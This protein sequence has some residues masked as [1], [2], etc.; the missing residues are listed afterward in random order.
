MAGR[1]A[2]HLFI[3]SSLFSLAGAVQLRYDFS[4][5]L[6]YSALTVAFLIPLAFLYFVKSRDVYATGKFHFVLIT[7]AWGVI[8]YFLAAQI[9]PA[10]I[11]AGWATRL[12]V[13]RFAGPI[14]EELLKSLILIYLVQRADY[15]YVVDGAIY[16][17]GAGIGFAIIENTEYIFGNPEIA[18]IVALAR[19]FSTNLVH[20]AGSGLIGVALSTNRVERGA[21]GMFLVL[22]GYLFSMAF[23]MGFNTMVNSGTILI[24]AVIF[25]MTEGGLII[26]AI[27]RGLHVQKGWMAEK[28]GDLNRVTKNEVQ[29]LNKMEQLDELLKPLALQFGD[30]KAAQVK[31]MLSKQAEMGIKTKLLESTF[32]ESKKQEMNG[33]IGSLRAE[34]E[35]LRGEIGFYC[36]LFVRQV[37]LSQDMN[38]WGA[39]NARIAESSTGQKGGGLWDRVSSRVDAS[40]SQEDEPL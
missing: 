6:I 5:F 1:N 11:D 36:M 3:I 15:N 12:Q 4:M 16:G 17:F 37:Y 24:F 32:N 14:V 28:L 27:R 39:I 13:I 30:E 40:K 21:K 2:C 9:N 10:L 19:V 8:A 38:L 29:A 35:V 33:I 25:G 23:H 7:I 34:M 26:Y 18:V 20:A 22:L 31:T